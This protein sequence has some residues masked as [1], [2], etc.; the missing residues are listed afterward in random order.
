MLR[1]I[2]ASSPF[3]LSR[4]PRLIIPFLLPLRSLNLGAKKKCLSSA[5]GSSGNNAA[6]MYACASGSGA[7]K[8]TLEKTKQYF[9]FVPVSKP[10]VSTASS[11]SAA[12]KVLLVAQGDS[13]ATRE[14]KEAAL[15]NAFGKR[16]EAIGSRLEHNRMVR[17]VRKRALEKR[18]I[19]TVSSGTFYILAVRCSA[20]FSLSTVIHSFLC[21]LTTSLTA[22][23]LSP[24]SRS[25]LAVSPR[26]SSPPG[27]RCVG[28]SPSCYAVSDTLPSLSQ[29][30]KLQQWKVT[31]V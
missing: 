27:R 12:N 13:I 22:P 14:K 19:K 8:T 6:V 16:A 4:F 9:L 21:R 3:P 29:G 25:S 1:G 5:Y 7:T 11:S 28:F 31:R 23:P 26:P 15:K 2:G 20:F 18:G 30:T 17:S 24:A 10:T